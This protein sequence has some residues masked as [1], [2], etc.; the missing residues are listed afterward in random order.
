MA[1]LLTS[2]CSMPVCL[3]TVTI[4]AKAIPA[5][6]FSIGKARGRSDE[7]LGRRVCPVL[8]F[9]SLL[10]CFQ[11]QGL[12]RCDD[13][14]ALKVAFLLAW[15][16]FRNKAREKSRWV[17]CIF[18][19]NR[20]LLISVTTTRQECE[21]QFPRGGS[22]ALRPGVA[23]DSIEESDIRLQLFRGQPAVTT[24]SESKR[25]PVMRAQSVCIDF[26]LVHRSPNHMTDG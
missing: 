21:D 4:L 6:P 23:G 12:D 16:W 7:E 18:F 19:T 2:S 1:N 26:V 20:E 13:A 22:T 11:H 17:K 10:V 9:R 15:Y 24:C 8:L 3:V 5:V 25:H 14:Q